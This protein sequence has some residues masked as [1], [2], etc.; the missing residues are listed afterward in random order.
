MD[1]T[2]VAGGRGSGACDCSGG[3]I[4]ILHGSPAC[5]ARGVARKPLGYAV[6]VEE[7]GA[8]QLQR[9][10]ELKEL[11]LANET[12]GILFDIGDCSA[13]ER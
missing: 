8:R 9:S 10:L 1:G 13:R 11:V 5:G 2:E 4:H 7:V 6:L 12:G 3:R